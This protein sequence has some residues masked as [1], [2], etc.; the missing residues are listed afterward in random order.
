MD[1][2]GTRITAK[3]W[4]LVSLPWFGYTLASIATFSLG[5]LLP[6]MRKEL[7]FGLAEAGYL[8]AVAWICRIFVTIPL[9][10]LANKF[11]PKNVH[12]GIFVFMGIGFVLQ[13]VA[14]GLPLLFV[15]RALSIGTMVAILT[16][17]V[18]TKVRW[19][20][21]RRITLINGLENAFGTAGQLIGSAVIPPLLVLMAGWRNLEFG[22]AALS[23]LLAAAW[24]FLGDDPMEASKP[25]AADA[26]S[27]PQA[28]EAAKNPLLEALKIK[29]LWLL[30]TAWMCEILAWISVFTFWPTFATESL[31]LTLQQAGVVLGLL[32][33]SSCVSSVVTPFIVDKVGY[34][35]PFMWVSGLV[36]TAAFVGM[37]STSNMFLL[38]LASATVGYSI[39]TF[40]PVGFSVLYKIPN[41]SPKVV[42]MG[43]SIIYTMIGIGGSLGGIIAGKLSET[44]GLYTGMLICCLFPLVLA[45]NTFFLPEQGRKY[46][47]RKEA[48]A[49]AAGA[50]GTAA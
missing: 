12:L 27:A 39:Y 28:G 13:G 1:T 2:T 8:S 42:P 45:V 36:M 41:I 22:L 46:L 48:A 50:S 23:F 29:E 38:C 44:Y 14:Q 30:S 24:F 40:V 43:I 10:Y 16:V 49:R 20:P 18:N 35:K 47:E 15:G 11:K 9:T 34:E 26:K 21:K 37:L 3:A 33:I 6:A 32:P 5:M 31:G 7:G 4:T 25:A 17:L 19:I